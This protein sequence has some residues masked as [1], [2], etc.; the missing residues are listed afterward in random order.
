MPTGYLPG[1]W[2]YALLPANVH[3][4]PDCILERQGSFEQYRSQKAVGL[5][6]GARVRAYTWTTFNVEPTGCIEIGD[7]CVLVGAVFMCA[8]RV[9][10]GRRVTISYGVT[11]ADSDFHPRDPEARMQDAVANAPFG[12]RTLR[13]AYRTAP[14]EIEDDVSVGIGA[15][16]LKGVHVGAAARIGAGAVVTADVPA[17]SRVEGNPGRVV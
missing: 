12:D 3:L 4:G 11:I 1:D 16:I 7:D 13:P 17:G 15:I 8:E 5:R 10:L 6:L 2:D 9:T 14:V